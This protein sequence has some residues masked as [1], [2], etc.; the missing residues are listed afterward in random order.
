[1]IPPKQQ[2]PSLLFP[3]ESFKD[4]RCLF[5]FPIYY[6]MESSNSQ[7]RQTSTLQNK[8]LQ[9]ILLSLHSE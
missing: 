1:V 9:P 5:T 4:I 6:G 3:Q 7:H 2:E 8:L